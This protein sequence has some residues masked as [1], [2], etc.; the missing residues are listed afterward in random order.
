MTWMSALTRYKLTFIVQI[1]S[2]QLCASL[3][4]SPAQVHPPPSVRP[5]APE[6]HGLNQGRPLYTFL[7][8]RVCVWERERRNERIKPICLQ[9]FTLLWGRLLNSAAPVKPITTQMESFYRSPNLFIG[10]FL[11][12]RTR[13]N[14]F[15]HR[16]FVYRNIWRLRLLHGVHFASAL[17]RCVIFGHQNANFFSCFLEHLGLS[18]VVRCLFCI[19]SDFHTML[20]HGQI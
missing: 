4:P 19:C 13:Q 8:A 20:H 3:P 18:L 6:G 10:A 2:D 15:W 16:N 11:F 5:L 1:S 17:S 9:P 12:Y 14:E 7:S